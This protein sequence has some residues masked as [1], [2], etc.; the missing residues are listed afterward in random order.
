MHSR[1]ST[2]SRGKLDAAIPH[3]ERARTIDPAH[4]ANG[5]DLAAR[6]ARDGQAGR[7][8]EQI[9]RMLSA[10]ETA[11]LHQPAR[12]RLRARGQPRRRG[13]S[14][15]SAPRAW[16]RPKS[17][18]STGGTTWCSFARSSPRRTSSPRRSGATPSPAGF[19][20]ASASPSTSRGQ[21]EDA[22]KSFCEAADL[23]PSDPR[24]YQFLGEMYGVVPELGGE[25]TKR[26]DALRESAARERAGALP[27]RDDS[28][29][30]TA[31]RLSR[32][33]IRGASRRCSGERSRSI[34][35]SRK[36]SW[37]SGSC[38]RTSSGTRKRFRSCAAR[39][40]LEP[41]WRKRITGWRRPT[42]ARART[43]WPRRSS[44]SS[45]SS[46]ADHAD[47]FRA[48]ARPHSSR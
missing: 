39:T 36:A 21:Y 10:K 41:G 5:Y 9:Q 22:V 47:P 4:Y 3:L 33:P 34:R 25:I 11:E 24:P 2:C 20:S 30:G 26:L 8:R 43:S 42:S 32:R 17:T 37:S 7:A 23:A 38:C 40:R 48:A 46:R 15:I 35:S 19:T 13:R 45:S 44:R 6:A 12:R 1:A 31:G 16:T 18:C 27:L 14:R 29:E 28:L